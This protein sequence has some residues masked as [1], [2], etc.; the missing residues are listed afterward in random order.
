MLIQ[1]MLLIAVIVVISGSLLTNAIVTTRAGFAQAVQAQSRTSMSDAT[2]DFVTWAQGRVRTRTTQTSWKRQIVAGKGDTEEFRPIC[3]PIVAATD[4][5]A[6][7]SHWE[8]N[9]W[10]VTGGTTGGSQT[11]PKPFG[12]VDGGVKVVNLARTVDEQRI[13][14]MVSTDVESADGR[15]TYASDSREI[16]ARTFDA[17]PWV[18]VTGVKGVGTMNGAVGAGEGDSG[19]YYGDPRYN[20][21]QTL[22]SSSNPAGITDT[23]IITTVQCVNSY[24]ISESSP[25]QNSTL[26]VINV[27]R[28]GNR[29]W[30]YEL[31]CSPTYKGP[32][33]PDPAFIAPHSS[34]YDTVDD[35]R[36]FATLKHQPD[37]SSFGK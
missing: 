16:T 19:G 2:A 35:S 6:A 32:T 31:P 33:V 27:N 36:S 34:T 7:C 8:H 15:E 14:A 1:A 10:M 22:P 20:S 18:V 11:Q 23:R 5:T 17:P 25:L 4:T 28:D 37:V 9:T 3:D 26:S 12:V 13:T 30:Q 21:H 29:D 24:N